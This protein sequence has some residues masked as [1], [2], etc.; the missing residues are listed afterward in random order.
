MQVLPPLRL[1]LKPKQTPMDDGAAVM[2]QSTPRTV[3]WPTTSSAGAIGSSEPRSKANSATESPAASYPMRFSGEEATK[4]IKKRT[5]CASSRGAAIVLVDWVLSLSIS[6]TRIMSGLTAPETITGLGRFPE[7]IPGA[8][9]WSLPGPGP[10]PEPV[11]AEGLLIADPTEAS[12]K[13]YERVL[14]Q[15]LGEMRVAGQ[16][17]GQPLR[18]VGV[19]GIDLAQGRPQIPPHRC[20]D[21]VLRRR[22]CHC[23]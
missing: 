8:I 6:S 18:R 23:P 1:T 9:P 19:N 17:V 11:G 22:L 21:R 13:L 14:R 5:S 3:P 2:L 12:G 15:V 16:E 4:K 7:K 10:Q 20:S